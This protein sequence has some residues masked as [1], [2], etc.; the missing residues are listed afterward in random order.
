MSYVNIVLLQFT[1]QLCS[2]EFL[3]FFND[4]FIKNIKH[5]YEC[6]N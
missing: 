1:V 5:K 3:Y 6:H 4:L 2:K